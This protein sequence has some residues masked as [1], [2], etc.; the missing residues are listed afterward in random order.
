MSANAGYL[1]KVFISYAHA[2]QD[3]ADK[4]YASLESKLGPGS[5]F[6]DRQGLVY[7]A[8]WEADLL[9][10]LNRSQHFVALW[11]KA[12]DKSGWVRREI[13][14]FEVQRNPASA[15]P[16]GMKGQGIAISGR[17]SPGADRHWA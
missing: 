3:W 1:Y 16:T 12:A 10:K 7:G 6:I 9:D 14:N 15:G 8:P 2:D 4:L 17:S 11:S 5:V 13:S